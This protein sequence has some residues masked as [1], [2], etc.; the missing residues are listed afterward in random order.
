MA[1]FGWGVSKPQASPLAVA[2]ADRYDPVALLAALDRVVPQY[3]ESVDRHELAYPACTRAVSDVQGDARAIWEHTRFEALRY[4]TMVPARDS[5]LLIGAARQAEMTS[6]FLRHQ[7]HDDT[8]IDFTGSAVD[9]V[10]IAI[11]AGLN[12]LNH[13]AAL[14]GVHPEKFARTLTGFR[15]LVRAAQQWWDLEGAPQRCARMLAGHE[16]PP[17]MLYLVW[18]DYTRLAR[19]IACA[20]RAET[21]GR[22]EAAQE[23]DEL[24]VPP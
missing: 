8:V 12:W 9:D 15:K 6:A 21:I 5:D 4:L 17:L 14:A 1:L 3:L 2:A 23:P 16:R 24:D 7:P 20:A 22:L 11:I 10:V 18:S 19:E 13:C